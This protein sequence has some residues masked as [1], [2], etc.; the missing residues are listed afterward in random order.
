MDCMVCSGYVAMVA[1]ALAI[2]PMM[3]N[4][5]DESLGNKTKHCS[6]LYFV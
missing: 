3:K 5:T 1:T 6:F 2:A 4:S